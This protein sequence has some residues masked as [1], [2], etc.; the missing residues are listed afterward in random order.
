MSQLRQ[1]SSNGK[2]KKKNRKYE[3]ERECIANCSGGYFH[4][5]IMTLK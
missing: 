4:F 2:K 3:E 5:L 1:N